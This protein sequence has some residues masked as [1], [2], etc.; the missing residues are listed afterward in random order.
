MNGRGR[1]MATIN[2]TN[3]DD[4]LYGTSGADSIFGFAGN[5]TIKGGGGAD[6][7]DGGAGVDMVFYSDSSI[8]VSVNLATGRGVGGT[9]DGDTFV[10]VEN[11]WGSSFNDT[12][13]GNDG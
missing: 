11:V 2:G 3:F 6:R 10:N 9:A 1:P 8:G 5:D 7:I 13:T 4:T 12:I